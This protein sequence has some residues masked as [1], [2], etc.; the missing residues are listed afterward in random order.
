MT[1]RDPRVG[2]LAGKIAVLQRRQEELHGEN[3]RSIH[4]AEAALEDS[5]TGREITL[6][7]EK[8]VG[9]IEEQLGDE[10]R[11]LGALHDKVDLLAI[12]VKNL[13]AVGQEKDQ[14]LERK[15]EHVG[16]KASGAR[17]AAQ[18]ASARASKTEEQIKAALE[19]A[20]RDRAALKASLD[21]AAKQSRAIVAN[22]PTGAELAAL[23]REVLGSPH[24]S[25]AAIALVVALLL[26]AAAY[27]RSC[28]PGGL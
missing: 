28:S 5:R 10:K 8:R 19:E 14:E 26:F 2:E 25:R 6:A 16:R 20:A 15:V 1:A 4:Q 12:A 13:A 11:G 7:V 18:D 24:V 21:A 22:P 27:V 17:H 3:L 9:A 23:R